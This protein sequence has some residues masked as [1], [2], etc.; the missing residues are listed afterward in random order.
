M[1]FENKNFVNDRYLKKM[2]KEDHKNDRVDKVISFL[3]KSGKLLEIGVWEGLT[4][5]EY[6]KN[7]QGEICGIDLNL[8]IMKPAMDFLDD[9]RACDLNT[10]NIPWEENTFDTV[11][12]TEIIEHVFDTDRLLIEINR[13]LKPGGNLI[14][15]TPNLSS[16]LNKIF[17]VFGLQPLATEVS[18]RKSNYGNPFR[19]SLHSSG[20]IRDFTYAAFREIIEA[21]GFDIVNQ[22][23]V[24]L[25]SQKWA[26]LLE[27]IAG[28]LKTSLGG[29]PI[30]LATKKA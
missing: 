9:A 2:E 16:I 29:N 14:I 4:T 25:S 22:T 12:C 20:H 7:Y 28:R 1:E 13:V 11:I 19:K 26:S 15:S 27:R 5:Q 6:R 24:P 8:D 30:L 10:D 21:N 23:S 3:P 17:I 18:C